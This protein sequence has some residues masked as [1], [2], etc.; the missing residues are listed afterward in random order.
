M[1]NEKLETIQSLLASTD[2]N[3]LRSGLELARQEISRVGTC[4]ARPL[5]EM[6]AAIF[7]ID[8]LDHPELMPILDEA[9]RTDSPSDA[10]TTW[11]FIFI[12]IKITARLFL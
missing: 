6:V 3:D 4:E 5:F 10:V 1:S 9:W 8:P 7:Y 12:L 2:P 11:L